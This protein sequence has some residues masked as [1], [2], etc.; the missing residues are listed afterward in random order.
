MTPK[1]MVREGKPAALAA[2]AHTAGQEEDTDAT[3]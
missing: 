2:L 1:Q 3:R